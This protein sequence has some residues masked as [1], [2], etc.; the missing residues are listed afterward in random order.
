MELQV[1]LLPEV[2]G[3]GGAAEQLLLVAVLHGQVHLRWEE[4]RQVSVGVGAPLGVPGCDSGF[5]CMETL[6]SKTSW[7]SVQW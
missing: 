4:S 3:A 2:P 5:T 6:E 7:Q 1:R